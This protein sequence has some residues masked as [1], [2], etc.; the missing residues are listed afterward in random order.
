[1]V[2]K[3]KNGMSYESNG[4]K[5][6]SINGKPKERGYAYGYLCSK[7]FKEIQ[8]TLKFLMMEAYGK[9]WDFFIN[10]VSSGFK[11]MTERDFPELYEEMEGITN[12]LNTAGTNT[13]IDEIIA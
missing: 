10:K 5:Y 13:T 12:G 3:V 11:E 6:I 7:E 2:N 4:W 1:M 8:N 9:D